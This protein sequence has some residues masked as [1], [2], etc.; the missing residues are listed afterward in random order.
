MMTTGGGQ[1]IIYGA[2]DKSL[3]VDLRLETDTVWLDARQMARLFDRN[4]TVIVRHIRNIYATKELGRAS[5][6]AR[7]AQVA[8][9]KDTDTIGLHRPNIYQEG[10]LDEP[11]T[12]EESSVAQKEAKRRVTCRV[13][14]YNNH[15]LDREVRSQPCATT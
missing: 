1:M 13:R 5:T 6:C 10:E 7:N 9:D 8:F 3:E 12:T 14:S 15:P 11:A 2:P 4:R